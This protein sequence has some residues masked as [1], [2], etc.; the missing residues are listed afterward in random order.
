MATTKQWMRFFL[1]AG[2]PPDS[3][4]HYAVTFE[5]NRM[6]LDMVGDLDKEYLRD[7]KITALGD[8]ISILRAAKKHQDRTER[9]AAVAKREQ[10]LNIKR[11]DSPLIKREKRNPS[12]PSKPTERSPSPTTYK[13]DLKILREESERAA[14]IREE[15]ERTA[16]VEKELQKART[17]RTSEERVG[18]KAREPEV[19]RVST[20]EK[21]KTEAE[22]V[23]KVKAEGKSVTVNKAPESKSVFSRLGATE[24]A[25]S[26]SRLKVETDDI[27]QEV[28]GVFGRLGK[29]EEVVVKVKE[30]EPRVTSTSEEKTQEDLRSARASASPGRGILKKRAA[31]D[32][33]TAIPRSKSAS[34]II[35][36]KAPVKEKQ[37]KRISFGETETRTMAPREDIRSRLGYGRQASPPP[38]LEEGGDSVMQTQIQKIALGGGKF[39]MRKVMKMVKTELGRPSPER[40]KETD[41]RVTLTTSKSALRKPSTSPIPSPSSSRMSA[42]GAFA[43]ESRMSKEGEEGR[44]LKISVKNDVT[45]VT[46]GKRLIS[47][48]NDMVKKPRKRL[49]MYRTLP[50]GTVE[51]EYISYDDPILAKVPIQ[52][53]DEVE[54]EVVIAK[55]KTASNFKV[56]RRTSQSNEQGKSLTL[57]EKAREMRS[58]EEEVDVKANRAKRFET[59]ASRAQRKRSPSPEAARPRGE[60][61]RSPQ[62]KAGGPVFARLGP[63]F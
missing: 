57:A 42:A 21:I 22:P 17:K 56:V 23:V 28:K 53:R 49:A 44:K 4:A 43:A 55:D 15:L 48:D 18:L 3:A 39:E 13:E 34:N 30:Q 47:E 8:I 12:P 52:K 14:R 27:K 58:R 60:R 62:R 50:D 2:I 6:G 41:Q 26:S 7:L 10:E 31:G 36:L 25:S 51:K 9:E 16:R 45:G 54:K 24:Q 1:D 37:T 33:G 61:E 63:R 29:Q 20:V 40:T 19:R 59:L 11:D 5:Q 32:V 35:S 38:E 46:A